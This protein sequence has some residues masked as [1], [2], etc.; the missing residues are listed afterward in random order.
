MHPL[1]G[2]M[3]ARLQTWFP[4]PIHIYR[5]G[6]EWLAQQ[7]KQAGVGFYRQ[8]NCFPWIEDLNRA[9]ELMNQQ[10]RTHWS[11]CFDEISQ[12]IHPL[13]FS[14]MSANYPMHYYWTCADSEWAMDL[15]FRKPE[16]LRRIVPRLMRLGIF[17]FSSP[18]VLRF[19]GKKVSAKGEGF[20]QPLPLNSDWK[21]RS[22]G[23]RIKHRLGPNSIKLY[24]KAY[25][26]QGAVLR[27]EVTIS[28][29][30]YFKIVRR[31]ED[32]RSIPALRVLRQSVSDLEARADLSQRILNR[33]CGAPGG[34][35]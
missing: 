8:G 13:L 19:M 33:Y 9:Q 32:P 2:L 20:R 11:T 30:K 7:M 28:V 15:M 31:T 26:A 3:S 4:F 17:T 27:A 12:Q 23:A 29:P 25:A 35:R 10:Q 1:F 6:R 34:H 22:N 14:E 24:D 18:D 5:N 16:Q 21:V